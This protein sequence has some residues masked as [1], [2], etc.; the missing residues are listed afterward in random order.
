M[1]FEPCGLDWDVG[2]FLFVFVLLLKS[3]L[4]ENGT[5]FWGMNEGKKKGY[6]KVAHVQA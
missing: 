5:F 4:Q 3:L 6:I 2:H 1:Y